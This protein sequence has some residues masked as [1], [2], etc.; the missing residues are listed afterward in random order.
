MER[1]VEAEA[2][3]ALFVEVDFQR[4]HGLPPRFVPEYA[5]ISPLLEYQLFSR[6]APMKSILPSGSLW[7]RSTP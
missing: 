1:R 3:V 2:V 6:T 5:W 7:L 4:P